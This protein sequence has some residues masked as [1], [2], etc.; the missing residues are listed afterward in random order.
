MERSQC[1]RSY[2]WTY[3][4]SA[5]S[6]WPSQLYGIE[7]NVYAQELASVVV[8]IGYIQW[9]NDNG[10]GIPP[11]PILQRLDNIRRMD[12][13]LR[14]DEQGN[15]AEPEWPEAD[16]IVGNP[17]FLGGKKMRSELGDEQVNDL[18]ELYK[19]RVP[20]EADFVASGLRKRG[21]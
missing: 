15:V 18:F 4:L 17:P 3:W 2:E 20:H 21:R 11:S 16:V 12:A 9:L 1:L 8:W 14:H 7:K 10:F 6:S 5:V 19:G 13:V